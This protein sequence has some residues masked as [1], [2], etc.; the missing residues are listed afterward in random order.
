MELTSLK[1]LT[2]EIIILITA[3]VT[4]LVGLGRT[5]TVRRAAQW[6]AALGLL[7]A[8]GV[9][10][11]QR[12]ALLEGAVAGGTV[13]G[14][15]YAT[16][17]TLLTCAI[18]FF[19]VL[20][21]WDMPARQDPSVT[22]THFRGEFF[23]MMLFSLAGVSMAGK[24]NDLVWLFIVLELV[25]IPTYIMVATSRAQAIAQEAGVKYFFLGALSAA[26]YLFGFSYLYGYAGSTRFADIAA[27]FARDLA[28]GQTATPYI[29]LIGLVMVA[30][31]IAYKIAA[32]PL[33]FY[34]PD[35][36]QGAA[37]PVTAFLAFAPKA[38][39]MISIINIIGLTGWQ[40]MSTSP[41]GAMVMN[42][43]IGRALMVLLSVM[44]ILTMTVG[45]VL[46]LLQRNIKRMLAYSSIAHSG[47]MLVGLAAGPGGGEGGTV[48]GLTATLF[49]LGAYAVM[50]LGAFAVLVYLQGKS[51]AGEE[52][53]DVAG[54]AKEHP[55][56][57][58]A[59][60][61]CLFSLI[62]MPLTIG[63]WGKLYLI[64]AA[65]AHG[66]KFLAIIT[67]INAAIAA[68]YYLRVVAAMYLREAWNP[69]AT[70]TS[71]ALR[72]AATALAV[73]VIAL[74]IMPQR[75]LDS[76]RGD[77]QTT[78]RGVETRSPDRDARNE[79]ANGETPKAKQEGGLE[80]GGGG[81]LRT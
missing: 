67:V 16:Y 32:V 49:Y 34:T 20:V 76:V 74:G 81:T 72:L 75:L 4:L 30:M 78:S 7:A 29:A 69:F 37:T 80:K 39:G 63:F 44:A 42:H 8:F 36:Y 38:A 35:V 47:Y 2:P 77:V 71:W 79:N 1:A 57:A 52:L 28:P 68:A 60:A 41:T 21:A 40:F 11:W 23:A 22:D 58:L 50:N 43:N 62:G 45:N 53:D 65:L 15:H 9:T 6:I 64:Q 13:L 14:M 55:A 12:D 27:V 19:S 51:E 61:L 46:A 24:V 31:G 33:H 73:A 18:G 70:R 48:D 54:V 59:L 66:H 26:V 3:A 25:S 5:D 17:L 10:A 56:A